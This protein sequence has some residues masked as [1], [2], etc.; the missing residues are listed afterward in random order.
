MSRPTAT[1]QE[2]D[3]R[4]WS[5]V[6]KGTGDQ[7]CWE[8]HGGMYWHGYGRFYDRRD[9][10]AHRY[11]FARFVSPIPD[12]MH[13]CHHCDNKKCVR[14]DH[15]FVG[16]R[17][18]NMQDAQRKGRMRM[19]FQRQEV[20]RKGLHALTV[21]NRCVHGCKACRKDFIA[22][23]HRSHRPSINASRRRTYARK[24]REA[25]SV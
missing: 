24:V 11:A 12:D 14:P 8:W 19:Q 16:T 22:A 18:D 25:V 9:V 23:W 5:R 15:L 13:I 6:K 10:Y 4:F 1:Q 3:A 17:S 7:A 21:S 2:R 20:C